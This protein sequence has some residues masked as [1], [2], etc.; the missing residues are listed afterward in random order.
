[1]SRME[2]MYRQTVEWGEALMIVQQGWSIPP[3]QIKYLDK[4][5]ENDQP[6]P[7]YLMPLLE[8]MFLVQTAPPTASYH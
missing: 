6:I 5:V 7:E 2:L 3:S 1:M 8:R 4:L